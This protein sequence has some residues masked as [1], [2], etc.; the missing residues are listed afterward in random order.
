[1][2]KLLADCTIEELTAV[3][4]SLGEPKFRARQIY[5]AV[6]RYKTFDEMTDLPKAV[7][8]PRAYDPQDLCIKRRYDQVFVCA[9]GRQY[10]RRRF[11]EV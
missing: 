5:R 7:Y 2:K 11:D 4:E 8:R 6:M 9:G 10:H 3:L 1:M